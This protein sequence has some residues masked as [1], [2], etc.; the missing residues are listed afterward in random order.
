MMTG[1]HLQPSTP[2][3]TAVVV[4]ENGSRMTVRGRLLKP[5]DRGGKAE[6]A[7]KVR[8]NTPVNES[9]DRG[10]KCPEPTQVLRMTLLFSTDW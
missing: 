3:D 4:K 6:A 9:L 10:Q 8:V 2:A 5:R 1:L 7:G